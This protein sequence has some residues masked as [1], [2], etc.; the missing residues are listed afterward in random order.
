MEKE[1]FGA[2]PFIIFIIIYFFFRKDFF[3]L[4]GVLPCLIMISLMAQYK[5]V[6]GKISKILAYVYLVI[7]GLISGAFVYATLPGVS[8]YGTGRIEVSLMIP[9]LMLGIIIDIIFYFVLK[10]RQKV[11]TTE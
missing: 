6:M 2:I 4:L 11:I 3:I 5:K 9:L 8:E 7:Y 10:N 1:Y